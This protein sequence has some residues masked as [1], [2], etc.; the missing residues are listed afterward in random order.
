MRSARVRLNCALRIARARSGRRSSTR[1]RRAMSWNKIHLTR[2]ALDPVVI[3]I[4]SVDVEVDDALIA[5]DRYP[6]RGR[7]FLTLSKDATA[8]VWT[9]FLET[10]VLETTLTPVKEV[11]KADIFVRVSSAKSNDDARARTRKSSGS[12]FVYQRILTVYYLFVRH[13]PSSIRVHFDHRGEF[14]NARERRG[15][16]SAC[17]TIARTLA[18]APS[19]PSSCSTSS[20]PVSYHPRAWFGREGWAF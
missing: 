9:D 3:V 13:I 14:I 11:V 1:R 19:S 17:E 2:C 16:L 18:P 12:W 5:G 10:T 8:L 15:R 6:R 4:R 7:T 20:S